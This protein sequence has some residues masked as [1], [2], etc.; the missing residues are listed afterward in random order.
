MADL[1]H[2][3]VK[4]AQTIA[5]SWAQ[6]IETKQHVLTDLISRYG[7]VPIRGIVFVTVL[8]IGAIYTIWTSLPT[9]QKYAN[10]PIACVDPNDS[11][12]S[13]K[14]ARLRFRNDA[15]AMLQ[16]GYRQFKGRPWY[17]P[18]PLGERLMLPSKYVEEIKT[19]PVD[20]VD[21]VATFF[22]MFEGKYTTMGSRSTLHPRTAKHDL[23]H[24]MARILEP[25]AE[26]IQDAFDAH[27]PATDEWRAINVHH[28]MVQIVA[29]VSSRMFGGTELSQ[30]QGWV[31]ATINFALDGFV[32]SDS[33][34]PQGRRA[35]SGSG[36]VDNA[37]EAPADFL[38]WMVEN[39]EGKEKEDSFIAQIQLKL[40]FAAI[41]TSAAAPTQ[42]LY[43]LCAMPQYIQP[44]IDEINQVKQNLS[45]GGFDKRALGKLIT[46]ERFVQR[47]HTFSDGFHIP[48]KTQI[49]VPT[50]AI[51]MDP[52][53]YTN[54]KDFDGFRFSN[55]RDHIEIREGNDN[56]KKAAEMGKLAYA[57]S[58]HESMAF[59]YGRHA[60][61]GRW[62]AGNEIKMIMVYL[63]ENYE[64]QFPGGKS[65]LE[66]RPPSMNY[67][68]QY[69]PNTQATVEFRKRRV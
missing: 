8:F 47:P 50:Q 9:K 39:A 61:P 29:R 26:E 33:S 6:I 13:L 23:N 69:L 49:G 3:S 64:F 45:G 35:A 65:G 7:E 51:S 66:N 63:L 52:E 27:L 16:Q 44:L 43:D 40:S 21:F 60:C 59:G 10:A 32:G 17:I 30:N 12:A 38:Q 68:T 46:F 20:E 58:N 25:V 14:E 28:A 19:A 18:S 24:Y 37:G 55:L 4:S 31:D 2:T 34:C 11:N 48:A 42:L 56:N 5:F 15:V 54:P 53:I 57:S 67:E 1:S 62:F 36:W 22:E 41:H